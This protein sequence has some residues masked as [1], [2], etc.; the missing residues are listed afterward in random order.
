MASACLLIR[1]AWRAAELSGGFNGPLATKEGLFV[2]LDSIP[3]MIMSILLTMLHS[4]FWFK[5]G[6]GAVEKFLGQRYGL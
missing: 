6:E 1:S 5:S 4:E 3:M 2:A